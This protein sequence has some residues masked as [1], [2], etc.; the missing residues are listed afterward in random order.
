MNSSLCG[1]PK[2]G[3]KPIKLLPM[4]ANST[5]NAMIVLSL[6]HCLRMRTPG[7][8]ATRVAKASTK[9]K[10]PSLDFYT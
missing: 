7:Y 8:E 6:R 4:K 1:M 5:P 3:Q 10:S 2:S 9:K